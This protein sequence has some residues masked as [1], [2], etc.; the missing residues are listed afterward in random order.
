[1]S[2]GY[3]SALNRPMGS[4]ELIQYQLE[5]DLQ[6]GDG[7]CL[8]LIERTINDQASS[9]VLFFVHGYRTSAEV[10]VKTAIALSLDVHYSGPVIVWSW[11]S[12]AVT[13]DYAMDEETAQDIAPRV[14]MFLSA[15][16][17]QESQVKF[18]LM[19]HSMGGQIL[20]QILTDL[21]PAGRLQTVN[22]VVFAAPDVAQDIFESKLKRAYRVS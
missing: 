6:N 12:D 20:L 17:R 7:G 18:D 16:L 9:R 11:P 8:S 14:G 10:A 15:L 3:V 21:T 5:N 19:A 13:A 2:V 1:V 22:S 4:S